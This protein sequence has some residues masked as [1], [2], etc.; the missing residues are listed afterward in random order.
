M[1]FRAIICQFC[2]DLF[3]NLWIQFILWPRKWALHQN[4]WRRSRSNICILHLLLQTLLLLI[5]VNRQYH[6]MFWLSQYCYISKWCNILLS[7]YVVIQ[8]TH[9]WL[10]HLD[11]ILTI[12]H[13]LRML[14]VFIQ[15][16]LE[17]TYVWKCR[18]KEM[19]QVLF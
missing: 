13:F 1:Y 2:P 8:N 4:S 9:P 19:E 17:Q 15:L 7:R 3:S 14:P 10:C 5:M 18:W 6:D 12:S 16:T 11:K